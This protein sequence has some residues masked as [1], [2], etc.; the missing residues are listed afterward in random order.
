MFLHIILA[1][2]SK[3]YDCTAVTAESLELRGGQR[4]ENFGYEI[5]FG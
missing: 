1:S 3:N 4:L 2:H 5:K